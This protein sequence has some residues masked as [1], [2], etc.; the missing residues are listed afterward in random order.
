MLGIRRRP[1]RTFLPVRRLALE[2]LG[3]RINPT[4]AANYALVNDWGSGFQSSVDIVN[5]GSPPVNNWRLEFDFPY[6]ITQIWNGVITSRVG[7]HYVIDHAGYNSTIF[8]NSTTN[9][10][11]LGVP[12]SVTT[13]PTNYTLNGVPLGG[14]GPI[15][16]SISIVDIVATEG[17]ASNTTATFTLNLSNSSA[18]PVTVAYGTTAET[19]TNNIDFIGQTGTV[20]FNPGVTQQTVSIAIIGDVLDEANESFTLNLANPTGATLVNTFARATIN[21]N[22]PL[23]ILSI[24]DVTVLEPASSTGTAPGYFSTLGNQIVDANN[25]PIRVAGVSWFGMETDTFAPHGLWLRGYRSM[26]DQMVQLGFNTIR[27]PFSNELFD[28]GSVPN[29][30]DFDLNPDLQGLNGLQIMD[31][32]VDYAGQVGLRIFLDHH[33]SDAGGGPNGNGLWYTAAYPESRFIS[34]WVMLANRY[35]GN[36]TV[37]GMDLHNEPHGPA[38]WGSGTL[39][40]DWRLAAERTGNEILTANPNLLIIVEGIQYATSGGYWWGGNLS[41][42]GAHPVRLNVGNRLVYSPHDYP[43]SVFNQS[44]FGAPNYPQNLYS[45]WD[46]N[47]GYLFQQNVAPVLLGEFGSKL[48][49]NVD[50]LWMNTMMKYLSGDFNGDGTSDLGP[51]QRGMSWTWWSWNPNSSD[52]GGILNDDWSTPIQSKVNQLAPIQFPWSQGGGTATSTPATFTVSLNVP[53]SRTI[54]VNYNTGNISA[55]SGT[56]FTATNGTVTFA[57]GETTKTIH[58]PV[59]SDNI[60]EPTETF[61]LTLSNANFSTIGDGEGIGTILDAGGPALPSLSIGDVTVTEGNAGTSNATFTVTLSAASLTTVSV[62]YTT[63][64]GSALAGSDYQLTNGLLSFAPGQTTRTFTVPIDG[65][66]TTEP[67][68]V[69]RVLLSQATN[70]TLADGEAQGIIQDNDTVVPNV[71]VAFVARSDWGTGFVADMSI[72]NNQ[73]TS[74]PSWTLEFDFD[75]TITNI[76]NAQIVSRVGNH[77]VLRGFSY[78]SFIAANGGRVEFGFQGTTGNVVGNGPR[79]Y[80]LN[81]VPLS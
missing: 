33:R 47:W 39:P 63:V 74:I 11:F 81:G 14:G 71:A 51:N 34:D 15:V 66:T 50:Q 6:T 70:A 5:T 40:N 68:E 64:D 18:T 57:P 78:N 46:A 44:W 43:A 55:S 10:G 38:S 4:L 76:W 61:R 52:T 1:L 23:P 2:P 36:P 9:F 19:A 72:T 65:D 35:A 67:T 22:D 45:L 29:G 13:P 48:E 26:M 54:T 60:V 42:A 58:V 8:T 49:T 28:A 16:P 24:S 41:N 25:Q 7:N 79:N 30:I 20:T 12:G 62:L 59:W 56:D 69:F 27:L 21:D 80:I 32:I 3:E 53:S 77:Y 75:R 31:K 17:D 73:A 37:I